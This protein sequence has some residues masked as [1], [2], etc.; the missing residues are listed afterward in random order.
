MALH[1]QRHSS[2]TRYLVA[3]T[4][5]LFTVASQ[6]QT[7][8]PI[9]GPIGAP[10]GAHGANGSYNQGSRG[11]LSA[12]STNWSSGRQAGKGNFNADRRNQS[13][14][15]QRQY[16]NPPPPVTNIQQVPRQARPSTS[17]QQTRRQQ[18]QQQ[19]TT[20]IRRQQNKYGTEEKI[21]LEPLTRKVART[22][23]SSVEH[24]RDLVQKGMLAEAGFGSTPDYKRAHGLYCEAARGGYPDAMVRLGWIYADGKGV[25]KNPDIAATLFERAA[26]FGSDIGRDL[27][28]R[29]KVGKVVIPT[30]LK[31]SVVEKGTPERA[32]TATELA[33]LSN[34][35]AGSK[36]P[37]V[38][39]A[40]A[41]I[42]QHVFKEARKYKLD[43][44]LVLA[45]MSTES[46][47]N[48]NAR[49]ERNAFGL[50]QL[51]PETAER[52]GVVDVLDPVQN[53][54]GGM[55]YLR[56]LLN[57]YRGDVS[58]V[59]AAYNAGEGAVDRHNGVPPFAETVAYVQRI[60]AAYPFDHHPYDPSAGNARSAVINKNKAL[61]GLPTKPGGA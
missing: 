10:T 21:N 15:L 9:G 52:F 35:T 7:G 39:A 25:T 8:G 61:S 1:H 3:S 42:V 54:R 13:H 49:S 37:V 32:A 16:Y 56:W 29:Y 45:V 51:I 30:C 20:V 17:V 57:Y 53:I 50:M 24:Y 19:A 55:A 28:G 2:R 43:P 47:F 18:Q 60:R 38:G 34:H 41:K 4:V 11:A 31:G 58:L 40:R 27:S 48:P 36:N 46:A 23:T 33:A 5:T 12:P 59:L 26:R 6:A 44:R 22:E 14:N